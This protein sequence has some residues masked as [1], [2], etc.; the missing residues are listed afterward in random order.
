MKRT[1]T[2]RLTIA[3]VVT[4]FVA[5]VLLAIVLSQFFYIVARDVP[6]AVQRYYWIF[7]FT[8]LTVFFLITSAIVAKI[9]H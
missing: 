8:V 4:T 9:V 5:F 2:A 1:M 7:L 3:L 6:P